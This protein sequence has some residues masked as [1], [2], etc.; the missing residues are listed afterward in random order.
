MPVR[1]HVA[2]IAHSP[3]HDGGSTRI[4]VIPGS[5]TNV[6]RNSIRINEHTSSQRVA[7]PERAIG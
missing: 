7:I 1:S 6:T 4:N 5:A 2:S 3:L